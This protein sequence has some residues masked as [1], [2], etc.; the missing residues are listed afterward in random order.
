MV[1]ASRQTYVAHFKS[2]MQWLQ[3]ALSP[4]VKPSGCAVDLS[5]A[6]STENKK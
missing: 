3:S 2:S 6:S 4:E 5:P 1:L